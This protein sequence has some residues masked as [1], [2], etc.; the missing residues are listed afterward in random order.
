M[1]KEY[2]VLDF[3]VRDGEKSIGWR[4]A[5][6]DKVR[7]EAAAR[8]HVRPRISEKERRERR[9]QAALAARM[10]RNEP[11][12]EQGEIV[13]W[14]SPRSVKR[15]A[16]NARIAQGE[17]SHWWILLFF[18]LAICL[19][20]LVLR[21][22]T[23][24]VFW[25]SGLFL[26]FAFALVPALILTAL[27]SVLPPKGNR[28]VRWVSA[29]A[30]LLLYAS[31]L[32]YYKVFGFFYSAYSMGNGGQVVE[33]WEV[34]LSTLLSAWLPMLLLIMPLLFLGFFGKYIS[35]KCERRLRACVL[36]LVLAIVLHISIV[37]S[38]PLY[39]DTEMSAYSLYHNTNDLKNAV[40]K[41]GY[42]AAF[43]LDIHRVLFGFDGAKLT[44]PKPTGNTE[45]T[46]NTEEPSSSSEVEEPTESPY[47]ILEIDFDSLIAGETDDTIN[48]LHEYFSGQTATKKNDKT[49]MFEGCNLILIT[50]E[51]FS[52]M[53]IDKDLTPTLYKMQQEGFN[54]TNFYT[55]IYG[56]STSDGEYIAVTGTIP[57][58]GV[59]SFSKSSSNAMPLTM[60]Q[61]LKKIGYSAYGYHNH[62][63]TYY[64]RNESHP[65]LGY[66]YKGLGNGLDVKE[67]WPESD[68]EMIDLTTAEY[69]GK[70]PFHA[71]YMTVSGHLEYSFGGNYIAS[72]N[73][74]L[75]ADLP[76]S[77]DVRAYLAC[78]IEFDRAME[79]LLQRLEEA[80]VAENTVIAITADHYPYGLTVEEQSE[81][82]GHD[83]E[84]N[85]ELYRN[86]CIIYKKGM[87]PE[88]VT[89]ACSSLDLLPTLSN[90]FGTEFDSRLYMGQDVFSEAKPL[91]IFSNRSWIT[92]QCSYNS[93]T[94]EVISLTG[95]E[96]SDEYVSAVRE[97][98]S[99]KFTV[100]TW[101][102][103]QDYW[104]TLFGDNLPP[105]TSNR[106]RR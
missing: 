44:L 1:E 104:R 3:D 54:F 34:V 48:Q 71:Y 6:E 101:V 100:S 41:M 9:R 102:L 84:E 55:P 75:V 13:G 57:K 5:Y 38:L 29:A 10:T 31:Q 78:N 69:M 32:I 85:F 94:G 79:L 8:R 66:I 73:R 56:V 26:S 70:E 49:G 43:R 97:I 82:A 89:R 63:Y 87:E 74:D 81:L 93:L 61:Q 24:D 14:K 42:A 86:A 11:N 90:L 37:I 52:H 83:L 59:W 4:G 28:I 103:E 80:G 45:N 21:A 46:D 77:S 7:E 15:E 105:G 50:A 16:R 64:D 91:I 22:V 17:R 96:I 53:A 40:S 23:A 72:Q 18:W 65:N 92:D 51:G 20:E 30:I 76:Y 36:P 35:C 25:A 62:T 95:E 67:T 98:V 88:T 39:G 19:S 33:F 58:A 68:V 60:V 106:P 47:N 27:C 99:N 2:G 12:E